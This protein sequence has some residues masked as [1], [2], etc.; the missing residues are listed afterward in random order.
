MLRYRP[1]SRI[2]TLPD[3]PIS[4]TPP[5]PYR[6]ESR[7]LTL[8]LRL[9]CRLNYF[10]VRPESLPRKSKVHLNSEPQVSWML[11]T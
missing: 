3:R 6:P 1:D 11:Y 10:P 4:G 2:D 9:I 8:P 5:L 7:I